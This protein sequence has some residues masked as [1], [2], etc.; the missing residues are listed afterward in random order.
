[1]RAVI[2][3]AGE[4]R[5]LRPLTAD[6]PK[7]MLAVAG[8]PVLEHNVSLLERSGIREI[9]INTHHGSDAI[10]RHFGDGSGFGVK[11]TYSNEEVL[12]GTA[13]ALLP[14][15]S[16]LSSTFIVLYGDNL[17]TCDMGALTAF[18]RAKNGIATLAVYHRENATAGGIVSMTPAGRIERFVEKPRED[19]IFSAWVNAGIMVCEPAI[20]DAIPQSPSDFG[21]DI[22]PELIRS[23]QEVYGYQMEEP[24]ERL[25]WIDSP[26]DYART[27]AE[28]QPWLLT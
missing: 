8:K 27:N 6:V 13:G 25:W 15:R 16:F 5:R 28:V 10:V 3:A 4:G 21:R 17:T 23:G 24:K 20:L 7:P 26:E 18:H 2:L 11:I 14:L 19:H 1:M 9:A 22:L 12:R